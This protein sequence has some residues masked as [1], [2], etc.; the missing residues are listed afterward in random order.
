MFRC[1]NW[2]TGFVFCATSCVLSSSFFADERPNIVLI[3]A[4]DLGYECISCNGSLDYQTPNLDRLASSGV[5]L[6]HCYS[7]PLCTPSRVKLMTGQSNKRNYVR[8]GQLDRQQITFAHLLRKAGYRTCVAGKWQ[9]GKEKDSPQH[10]GFEQSLLWQHTRGRTD[11]LGHDTR[12]PNPKLE[13]NGKPAKFNP[14]KFSTDLFVDYIV[15]FMEANKEQPFLVYYPMV[16][17]H[18]PFCATPDSQNWDAGA[19]GSKNYKGNPKYFSDMVAYCDKSVG[20]IDSKLKQLGIRDNTLLIFVGDNGTDK[21]IVTK[22]TSGEIAGGKAKMT[23]AGTHVPAVI[24]WPSQVTSGMV[25]NDIV[26]F[27]DFMPTICDASKSEV[28]KNL[29]ID[30]RTFLPQIKGE[31]GT[32]RDSIYVWY[33][34]N[35]GSSNAR[36]FARNQHYKLYESGQF[37]DIS[38]DPLEGTPIN[39]LTQE[40]LVVRKL[41]QKRIDK[42]ADVPV[43]EPKMRKKRN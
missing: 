2:L 36:T 31:I 35:G 16:L 33:S 43:V 9:L 22:T 37:Y 27:S 1:L 28:P 17:V 3:M 19:R 34:R 41:L 23:D 10:I 12:Y 29:T 42:F 5:R 18:C 32:P 4:D 14:G 40:Q 24:S 26:D 8:F 38:S 11:E 20:R 7:Q 30:G 15:K 39:S 13:E 21:P 6:T 25:L